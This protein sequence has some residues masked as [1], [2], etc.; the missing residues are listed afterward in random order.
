MCILKLHAYVSD[1]VVVLLC[2]YR[3]EKS[4][5]TLDTV[6]LLVQ[7]MNEVHTY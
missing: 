5:F 3:A 4:V 7:M 6:R 1:N 2:M